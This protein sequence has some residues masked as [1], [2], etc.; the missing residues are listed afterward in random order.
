PNPE[1]LSFSKKDW[2]EITEETFRAVFKNSPIKRT[3]F[4]G[5]KRNIKF[6]Q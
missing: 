3:K 6:L 5:L 2:I 1:L 4:D